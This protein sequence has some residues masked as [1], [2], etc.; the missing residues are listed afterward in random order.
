MDVAVN[1]H[2]KLIFVVD[3]DPGMRK[4]IAG[5]LDGLGFSAELYASA[6]A[7]LSTSKFF[8]ARDSCVILDI[9][10]DGMSG[11]ELAGALARAGH[12]LPIIFITGN[13][14]ESVRT[15]AQRQDCIAFLTKP[16]TAKALADAID[17]ALP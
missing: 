5:L 12:A 14:N 6:E 8:Q 2:R 3:D 1:D 13:D 17:L 7:F 16:F 15:A 9:H 11:I 4:S 10:L